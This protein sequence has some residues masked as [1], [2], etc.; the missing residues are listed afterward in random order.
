MP[1]L[2]LGGPGYPRLKSALDAQAENSQTFRVEGSGHFIS[3][4]KPAELLG[5]LKDFLK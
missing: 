3:E 2:G 5:H 4:E 1:V